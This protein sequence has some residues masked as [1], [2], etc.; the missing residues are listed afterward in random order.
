MVAG[1]ASGDALGGPLAEVLRMRCPELRIGGVGGPAM[2]AAGV[3]VWGDAGEIEA[4]GV[5]EAARR[6][7][8][9]RRIERRILQAVQSGRFRVAVLIDYPGFNL[10]MAGKLHARGVRT[11]QFVAPQLWGWGQWRARRIARCIDK[12]LVIFPFEVEYFRSLGIPAIFVGHP[13]L[14]SIQPA[15]DPSEQQR[16]ARERLGVAG[17]GPVIGLL[18]GSR[19]SE[20]AALLPPMLEAMR[21]LQSSRPETQFLLPVAETL[22]WGPTAG[23]AM[24][25][26]AVPVRGA[27]D[28]LRAADAALIASGTATLEAALLGTPSVIAYRFNPLTFAIALWMSSLPPER[29][30][31]GLVNILAAEEIF[32]ELLQQEVNGQN[33][34]LEV[35]R[36]MDD[37]KR[38][39]YVKRRLKDIRRSLEDGSAEETRGGKL[40][41]KERSCFDR[42][43]REIL[44]LTFG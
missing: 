23:Q 3:N 26:G 33:L 40:P 13:L 42:A 30:F 19:E 27:R 38:R 25:A 36:L 7:S 17:E 4:V 2:R 32:P 41:E 39:T 20:L 8:A 22:P 6:L 16:A 12:L 10:Y 11:V 31:L 24:K 43:A 14:E 1:E 15:S 21:I 18:P 9:L 29:Y 37:E 35:R 44:D 34:S 5:L 28:V